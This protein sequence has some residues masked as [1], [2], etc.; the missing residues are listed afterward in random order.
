MRKGINPSKLAGQIPAPAIHRVV[1]PVFIPNT[2]DVYFKEALTI[3]R[4]CVESL[5]KTTHAS[6]RFTIIN[7]RSCESVTEFLRGAFRG[8]E[9]F[10]QYL[11]SKVNLGK[12]NAIRSAVK[13]NRELLMTI[14]DA[15][16]LFRQGWQ[17]EVE[18]LHAT[19]PDAGMISPAVM[20]GT[21]YAFSDLASTTLFVGLMGKG[22]RKMHVLDRDGIESFHKSTGT[23]PPYDNGNLWNIVLERNG[24]R[25][26]VGCSH[27]VATFKSKVFDFLPPSPTED[28]LSSESDYR[29]LDKPNNAS[30][31]L[32]LSTSKTFAFH[33][34]NIPEEWMLAELQKNRDGGSPVLST[35]F[36]EMPNPEP[37]GRVMIVF[38][39]L[40]SKAIKRIPILKSL[41]IRWMSRDS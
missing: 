13:S 22:L 27:F 3:L 20:A 26:V 18:E 4:Y 39:K 23:V 30:G 32:R 14:T 33:M 15:D 1:M 24:K 38:G 28:L 25:A 11:E 34:G 21:S 5:F 7:N 6:T 16:V 29:H 35:Y 40:F 9:R 8:E 12:I 37:V 10:D 41:L 17:C 36:Y 2:E 31:F 19:F